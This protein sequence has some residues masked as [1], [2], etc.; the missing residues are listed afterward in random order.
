[1][2]AV[3]R[4]TVTS[5]DNTVEVSGATLW[6]AVHECYP[7]R[8][9]CRFESVFVEFHTHTRVAATAKANIDVAVNVRPL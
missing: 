4:S 6:A 7:H 5:G 2:S 3:R 8:G 1:M 9:A